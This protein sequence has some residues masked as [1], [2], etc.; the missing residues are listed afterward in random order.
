MLTNNQSADVL[1]AFAADNNNS[2]LGE[3]LELAIDHL[4]GE[5]TALVNEFN[6]GHQLGINANIRSIDTTMLCIELDG[7][8][9]ICSKK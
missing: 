2:V 9:Y 1:E 3:A 5:S 7:R 6:K 4:R 8:G